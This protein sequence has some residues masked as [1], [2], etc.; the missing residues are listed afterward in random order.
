MSALETVVASQSD[1]A[2][3]AARILQVRDHLVGARPVPNPTI[4]PAPFGGILGQLQ[5]AAARNRA[6]AAVA[7][8][9]LAEVENALGLAS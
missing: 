4:E 6:V 3:L 2:D 1:V 7:A 8:E 5:D 9:A